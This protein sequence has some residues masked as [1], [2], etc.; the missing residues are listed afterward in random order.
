DQ[1]HYLAHRNLVAFGGAYGRQNAGSGGLDLDDRLVSLDLHQRLPGGD[2]FTLAPE[3]A[4]EDALFLAHVQR[5]HDDVGGHCGS[6]TRGPGRRGISPRPTTRRMSNAPPR[7]ARQHLDAV[8]RSR[9]HH[10]FA[11]STPSTR[12]LTSGLGG[13]SRSRVRGSGPVAVK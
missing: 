3:P 2:R 7:R 4:D 6:L 1:S 10:A 9:A 13:G 12:D 11:P 5:G 8:W